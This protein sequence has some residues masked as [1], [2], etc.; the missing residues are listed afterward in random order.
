MLFNYIL[1]FPVNTHNLELYKPNQDIYIQDIS[2]Y[3]NKY[4]IYNDYNKYKD[5][6]N[7]RGVK[8]RR[9]QFNEDLKNIFK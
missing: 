9:D 6:K 2:K 4:N 1:I 5:D 8:E 3:Y 7:I